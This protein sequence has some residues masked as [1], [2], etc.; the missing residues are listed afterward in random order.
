MTDTTKICAAAVLALLV[1]F[2]GPISCTIKTN[3]Q[4]LSAIRAGATP[5]QAACAIKGDNSTD[6]SVCMAAAME[7]PTHDR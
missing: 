5:L 2:A 1:I 7:R 6:N 4:V 3:E